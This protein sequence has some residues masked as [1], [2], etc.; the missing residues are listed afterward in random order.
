MNA[1]PAD[2]RS[3]HLDLEDLI[4][5]AACEATGGRTREHL[6]RCEHCR[7]EANRWNLI[8]DGVRGLVTDTPQAAPPAV[9]RR[10]RPRGLAGPGGAR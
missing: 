8:A 9:P 10:T 5:G 2:T 7:A 4:A 6:A 1:D 3:P